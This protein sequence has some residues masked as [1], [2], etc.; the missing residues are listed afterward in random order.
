MF[1]SWKNSFIAAFVAN[2]CCGLQHPMISSTSKLVQPG[3][4]H[5]INTPIYEFQ[6][7]MVQ[8]RITIIPHIGVRRKSENWVCEKIEICDI[9]PIWSILQKEEKDDFEVLKTCAS[10]SYSLNT[11]ALHLFSCGWRERGHFWP[12]QH[13]SA[14]HSIPNLEFLLKMEKKDAK[15]P[16]FVNKGYQRRFWTLQCHLLN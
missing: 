11:D 10:I 2:K 16:H 1:C 7:K 5:F 13:F 12:T 14:G 6:K 3:I 4:A 9:C 15:L 8:N